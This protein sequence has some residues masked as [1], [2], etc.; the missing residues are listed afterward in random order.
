[1]HHF[2][3]DKEGETEL[4]AEN[5]ATAAKAVNAATKGLHVPPLRRVLSD[6]QRKIR[7]AEAANRNS[8]RNVPMYHAGR[9]PKRVGNSTGAVAA[10]AAYSSGRTIIPST[11][12]PTTRVMPPPP[13]LG[14]AH[15]IPTQRMSNSML[16][17][18]RPFPL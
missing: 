1:M 8:Q 18:E 7:M 15:S 6:I 3:S 17:R 14:R 9:A 2:A 12:A 4:T 11:E 5:A 10:T 13:R 16:N